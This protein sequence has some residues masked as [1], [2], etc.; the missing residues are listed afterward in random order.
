MTHQGAQPK[1]VS[2]VAGFDKSDADEDLFNPDLK[3]DFLFSDGKESSSQQIRTVDKKKSGLRIVSDELPNLNTFFHQTN[4]LNYQDDDSRK[5]VEDDDGVDSL[6][7]GGPVDRDWQDPLLHNKLGYGLNSRVNNMFFADP[8]DANLF[9]EE[10]EE[11]GLGLLSLSFTNVHIE[12][13]KQKDSHFKSKIENENKIIKPLVF[14]GE[15]LKTSVSLVDDSFS[16]TQ[17]TE[18]PPKEESIMKIVTHLD[19]MMDDFKLMEEENEEEKVNETGKRE[20]DARLNV[21]PRLSVDDGK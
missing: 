1:A 2:N 14:S 10:D 21:Y 18:Q 4:A 15:T 3:L 12:K 20:E 6:E 8:F 17:I 19:E 9:D 11:E 7:V 13:Q 16:M 5:E